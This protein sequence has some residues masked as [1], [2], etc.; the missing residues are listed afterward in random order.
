MRRGGLFF[1]LA[2]VF[3]AQF[4]HAKP[5][6]VT[7]WRSGFI[8]LNRGWAEHDGDNLAWAETGYDDSAWRTVDLEDMGAAEPGWRWFRL[9][10]NL[11]KRSHH[12]SIPARWR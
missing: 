1:L 3:T 8:E 7:Q 10:V 6:A 5:V 9:H 4:A 2:L 11:G 12:N